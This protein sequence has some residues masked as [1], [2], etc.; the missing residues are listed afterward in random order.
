VGG[1]NELS[2]LTRVAREA[3]RAHLEGRPARPSSAGGAL[4]RRAPVFVTLRERE[5]GE[6][7]GCIG[8]LEPKCSDLVAETMDRAVAAAFADPRFPPLAIDE[9]TRCTI[10][11]SILG[12]LLPVALVE[13]LDPRRFGVEISDR[14][15][16]RAVL[17]PDVPGVDTVARQLAVVRKKAGIPAGIQVSLRRFEV[18][19]VAE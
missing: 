8:N 17:L 14:Q 13:E 3:I 12:P 6:L 16:R 1:V 9:L 5:N 7:R 10:E 19:R 2:V 18:V 15:G 4:G 11:V